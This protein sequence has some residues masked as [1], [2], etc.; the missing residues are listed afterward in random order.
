SPIS[1]QQKETIPCIAHA[2]AMEWPSAACEA[3]GS[4]P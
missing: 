1:Y 3:G 4:T 2:V